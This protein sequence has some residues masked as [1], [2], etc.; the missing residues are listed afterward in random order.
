MNSKKVSG[1]LKKQLRAIID[2][3]NIFHPYVND[4][5]EITEIEVFL[6]IKHIIN[7][8][9]LL[10]PTDGLREF[11]SKKLDFNVE[12]LITN[13]V[14]LSFLKK[15]TTSDFSSK[16][17]KLLENIADNFIAL[18]EYFYSIKIDEDEFEHTQVEVFKFRLQDE[19]I[20]GQ[21]SFK[22]KKALKKRMPQSLL[23][24]KIDEYINAV[25]L[26]GDYI[27]RYFRDFN[28]DLPT[29]R[30]ELIASL[31]IPQE[32]RKDII[33]QTRDLH[34]K[35]KERDSLS[36]GKYEYITGLPDNY[37]EISNNSWYYRD[38]S[39]DESEFLALMVLFIYGD[40]N[41]EDNLRKRLEYFIPKNNKAFDS[42][43]KTDRKKRGAK[44]SSQKTKRSKKTDIVKQLSHVP[45]DI[46]IFDY[47]DKALFIKG[48]G[49]KEIIDDLKKMGV[50]NRYKKGWFISKDR[51][52][53]ILQL[54]GMNEDDIHRMK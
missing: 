54:L 33:D 47:S 16:A 24:K 29:D 12:L 27:E 49:T 48:E 32:F 39:T 53:Q 22:I 21:K 31:L 30:T 25:D 44:D 42:I 28:I 50:W 35:L 51:Q 34:D 6:L 9:V 19:K 3:L 11:M 10:F 17:K 14:F 18:R 36:N 38:Y 1:D 4:D 40:N 41:Y 2:L 26:A 23:A 8:R 20:D 46:N 7:C 13:D 45:D 37:I 15:I 52:K 43:I 5:K